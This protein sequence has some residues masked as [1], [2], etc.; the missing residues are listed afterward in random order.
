MVLYL[1]SQEF[2]MKT[3]IFG[4]MPHP[5]RACEKVLGNDIGLKMLK[6]FLF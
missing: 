3:K 5:E 4:L 1:I 6:G 2:V